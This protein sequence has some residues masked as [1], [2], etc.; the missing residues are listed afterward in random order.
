MAELVFTI[1]GEPVAKGRPRIGKNRHTGRPVAITPEKTLRFESAVRHAAW[2][3][4]REARRGL[5]EGPVEVEV[6]AYWPC[7]ANGPKGDRPTWKSTRPDADNVGKA[8]CDAMNATVYRDDGQVVALTVKKYRRERGG[9]AC[10]VVRVKSLDAGE[11]I[12]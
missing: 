3:A 8:V 2:L 10:T 5:L 6:E 12:E 11:W 9:A 7:S 4:M 1:P